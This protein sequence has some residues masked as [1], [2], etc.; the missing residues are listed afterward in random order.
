M[1]AERRFIGLN[2]RTARFWVSALALVGLIDSIYLVFIKYA[3]NRAFCLQGVGDCYGVNSS[4]Y[5]EIYGIPIAF[6]GA[7]AYVSILALSWLE[8]RSEFFEDYSG[9]LIFGITLVGVLYS[10]YL[11][12]IEVAVLK[13]ICPFCVL[14]ATVMIILFIISSARLL[15]G[16]GDNHQRQEES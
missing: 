12:Y 4:S 10:L 15:K 11:T 3:N 1:D 7:G 6:L 13:A 16:Q 2:F 5:S 9:V 14:S 8:N